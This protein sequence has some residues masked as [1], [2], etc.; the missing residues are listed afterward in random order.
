MSG[1]GYSIRNRGG[2]GDPSEKRQR[3]DNNVH[4]NYNNNYSNY[5]NN[6]TNYN[7]NENYNNNSSNIGRGTPDRSRVLYLGNVPKDWNEEIIKSVV[8]GSGRVVDIRFR[9]DPSGRSKN[10][11]F[12]EYENPDEA[13]KGIDLLSQV[14]L[15]PNKKLRVELSKEALKEANRLKPALQLTRDHLPFYV[16]LPQEMVEAVPLKSGQ[17][18]GQ[19][20]SQQHQPTPLPQIAPAK[21]EIPMPD[22]LTKASQFLPVF[23]PA[24]FSMEDKIAQNLQ[25]LN[26]PQMIQ[27]IATM[28]TLVKANPAAAQQVFT[29]QEDI[30]VATVQA[31]LLMGLVDENVLSSALQLTNPKSA[32]PIPAN[33]T[34]LAS[35]APPFSYNGNNLTSGSPD[36]RW[37]GIPPRAAAKLAALPAESA[38]TIA[39]VLQ[40]DA[41]TISTLPLEQQQMVNGIRAEYLG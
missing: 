34:P 3:T 5:N 11:I 24:A 31:L 7:N 35:H 20:N 2:S 41:N 22:I 6:R 32:T 13:Q 23:N 19:H 8:A 27:L 10:Y 12:V 9:I 21:P 28:K 33:S 39:H 29:V 30:P 1:N 16:T 25:G 14:M 17:Q 15:G 18:N 4:N 26:P 40:L 36:P 37:L 38:A